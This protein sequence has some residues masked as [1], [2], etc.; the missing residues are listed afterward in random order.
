[1]ERSG[2][3]RSKRRAIEKLENLTNE[4]SINS[5]FFRLSFFLTIFPPISQ[6]DDEVL[7]LA[8]K[9]CNFN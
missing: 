3:A 9:N 8:K 7:F 6:D 1:V 2:K 5:F 4:S